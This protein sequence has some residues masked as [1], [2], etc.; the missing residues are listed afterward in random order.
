MQPQNST[1]P[2]QDL[3]TSPQDGDEPVSP[4]QWRAAFK[5]S[6]RRSAL[7]LFFS[8]VLPVAGFFAFALFAIDRLIAR[9]EIVVF[10]R[11][12]PHLGLLPGEGETVLAAR[13][14][15]AQIA[16]ATWWNLLMG[17]GVLL[18]VVGA[19]AIAARALMRL[20]ARWPRRTRADLRLAREIDR[21]FKRTALPAL[22][23]AAGV[24][25]IC[26]T[27]LAAQGFRRSP[28]AVE[29]DP[30]RLPILESAAVLL[31]L[32]LGLSVAF[33]FTAHRGRLRRWS[34]PRE[35]L[36]RSLAHGLAAAVVLALLPC[37]LLI[38]GVALESGFSAV[39]HASRARLDS[40][41]SRLA[42]EHGYLEPEEVVEIVDRLPL[43]LRAG[44]VLSDEELFDRFASLVSLIALLALLTT[45]LEEALIAA[46][47]AGLP[48]VVWGGLAAF[49]MVLLVTVVGRVGLGGV[50]SSQVL[51]LSLYSSLSLAFMAADLA[52]NPRHSP[53][54]LSAR[55]GESLGAVRRRFQAAVPRTEGRDERAEPSDDVIE[56]VYR[57]L[58]CSLRV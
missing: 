51:A 32:M 18:A 53:S 54:A 5:G 48:R 9:W 29:V 45:G 27:V 3:P 26:L 6:R 42:A 44:A 30:D 31:G 55:S 8:A 49:T 23:A 16:E 39:D 19:A 36:L 33:Q 57:R 25:F 10:A 50:S 1:P 58:G 17:C 40:T 2:A 11:L 24:F 35:H 38:V 15:A 41:L 47:T 28:G 22:T 4:R 13:Q 46:M 43:A 12:S 14:M 34:A 56:A 52:L 37:L 21:D 7:S 20:L